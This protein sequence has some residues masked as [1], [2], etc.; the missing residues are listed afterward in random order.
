[1]R[2][3]GAQIV[4]RRFSLPFPSTSILSLYYVAAG[5]GQMSAAYR[6]YSA[7]RQRAV[8]VCL[9][10]RLI[11]DWR[12]GGGCLLFLAGRHKKNQKAAR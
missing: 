6:V 3:F 4:C 2:S 9:D 10:V 1:M 12:Q 8:C 11:A 7:T 5:S